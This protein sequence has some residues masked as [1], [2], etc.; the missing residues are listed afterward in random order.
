MWSKHD[1]PALP[2]ELVSIS[3][4]LGPRGSPGLELA[5][6]SNVQGH[7]RS[8]HTSQSE[9]RCSAASGVHVLERTG[10]GSAAAKVA[11]TVIGDGSPLVLLKSHSRVRDTSCAGRNSYREVTYS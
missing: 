8:G 5:A 1:H 6:P 3:A 9:I 11:P 7:A 2:V 4:C 10:A